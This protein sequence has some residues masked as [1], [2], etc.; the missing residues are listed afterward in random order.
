MMGIYK[1]EC[2]DNEKVY[3]GQSICI[4]KRYKEHM[5]NHLNPN[6][7]DYD[8]KFYR[9]LRKHGFNNFTFEI[10]ASEEYYSKEDL[11]QME[12]DAIAYYNS[13]ENGYNSNRGGFKVTECGEEH[14]MA[15]LTNEQVLEIKYKLK[16]TTISQYQLAKEYNV[17]QSLIAEI[18]NGKRWASVGVQSLYPI[19]N[20]GIMRTGSKNAKAVLT[21]EQVMDIRKRCA[22]GES[23][24][25]VFNDYSEICSRSTIDKVVSG[26]SYANLPIYDNKNKVW[27]QN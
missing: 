21:D 12:I 1:F 14:P 3:I 19:R 15:K 25:S 10:L 2:K 4:E 17:T 8:T 7:Q 6:I 22:N 20:Q 18:N 11:N 26:R 13:Y 27:I 9:A 5:N 23:R 24:T 16:T